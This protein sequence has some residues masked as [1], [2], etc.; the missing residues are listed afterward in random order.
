MTKNCSKQQQQKNN[1]WDASELAICVILN[2][3]QH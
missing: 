1:K 2:F 3:K